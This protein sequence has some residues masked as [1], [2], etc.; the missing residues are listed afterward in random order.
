MSTTFA[1]ETT[2]EGTLPGLAQSPRIQQLSPWRYMWRLLRCDTRLFVIN[3]VAW[4]LDHLSPLL[5]GLV[6]GYYFDALA[7]H[8]PLG[9]SVWVVVALFAAVGVARFGVF[10]CGLLTWFAYYFTVQSLLRRNLFDWVMRGPGTHRLPD[11]PSE[12]MS[13]FR[14]DV[15][16][17]SRLFESWVDVWGM[18][19][20][21]VLA[22]VIMVRID[23]LIAA[24]VFVPFVAL[25]LATNLL[26]GYLT[27]LRIANRLATGRITDFIGELFASVQA[28]KVASAE[29]S[30]VGRFRALNARRRKTAVLDTAATQL[31]Q[32]VNSN[33]GALGAAII[34]LL[35]AVHTT[36]AAFTL[37]DF[38]IFVTYLSDLAGR[39]GWL[40][41]S[42]A[43]QRQVSVSFDRMALVMQG[44]PADALVRTDALHLHG[45]LPAYVAKR[46]ALEEGVR[47]T[48]L[49]TLEV[50]NLTYTHP[51][52]GRGIEGISLRIE[53]GQLVV[54]TGRI[55]SGK[56][57]LVRTLLGQLPR[58]AGAIFW[59]GERVADPERF[60]APPRVAYT[61]QTPRLFSE[62]LAANVLLGLDE[63]EVDLPGALRAALLEHDL[64]EMEDGL[65]TLVGPR[66]VRLSG[67][68]VQRVA[69]A[70]M[71]VRAADLLVFDD[72]SSALDVETERTMWERLFTNHSGR[73]PTCL[74]VS[75]RRPVL[76]RADWIVVLRDGQI[77][78][79]GTLDHL[80]ATSAE[81]RS[82]WAGEAQ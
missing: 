45:E 59:N 54:V 66:G 36:S 23:A 34:L 81:M 51:Q 61:P 47:R 18:S 28:I 7:G 41:Q 48:P 57:T 62:T 15:E 70:R 38:A 82:L 19:L 49:Q 72:L 69:A 71:F 79:E 29:E 9:A 35:L 2:D 1:P 75:H 30:V 22:L 37:A 53:R 46:S 33:M 76:Q 68:Q 73:T 21:V 6:I 8:G 65:E 60:F 11:S 78:A 10:V 77:E 43:R 13:R 32:S 58:D 4:T 67:G 20:Y 26:G 40:G 5:T 24:L 63:R 80:L 74:V 44:A 52:S 16:E 39:M 27:R 31:L 12:A 25:L 56:T 14:D 50:A 17:V 42:L 3:M 55:G 64:E